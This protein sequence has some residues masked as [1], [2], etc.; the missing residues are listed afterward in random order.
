MTFT[1]SSLKRK[2]IAYTNQFIQMGEAPR[3]RHISSAKLE[4]NVEDEIPDLDTIA[5]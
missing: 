4:M 2:N 5:T 3:S 1:K